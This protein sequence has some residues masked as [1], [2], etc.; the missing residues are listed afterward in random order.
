MLSIIQVDQVISKTKLKLASPWMPR[1]QTFKSKKLQ[2][3][4][5]EYLR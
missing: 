3:L 2:L 5:V 4:M 1:T